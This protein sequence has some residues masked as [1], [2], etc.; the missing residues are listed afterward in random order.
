MNYLYNCKILLRRLHQFQKNHPKKQLHHL[1]MSKFNPFLWEGFSFTLK[2]NTCSNRSGFLANTYGHLEEYIIRK[3]SGIDILH[4][5]QLDIEVTASRLGFSVHYIDE[6][7]MFVAGRIFL[8]IRSTSA[9]RWQEFGHEL[10]HAL[11]HE[12]DQALA[13]AMQREYQENKADNFAQH[14]CIPSFMLNNMN[15]PAYEPEAV[16]L[17]M[18]TFGVERWFAEKRLQ[19]YMRNLMYR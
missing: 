18:E 6:R 12:G 8:D 5:Y 13:T 2:K 7:P 3:L 14:F 9:Q 19:Q 1:Q 10:C 17:I 4:P 15:L 16:W 11:L